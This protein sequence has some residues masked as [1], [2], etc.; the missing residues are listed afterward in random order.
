MIPL[1]LTQNR[2][3]GVYQKILAA[4]EH[5][6]IALSDKFEPDAKDLIRKLLVQNPVKRIGMM[7]KGFDDIWSHPFL[8]GV[9]N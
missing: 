2:K 6:S 8:K 5:L 1:Y 7:H 3:S 9:K 4:E